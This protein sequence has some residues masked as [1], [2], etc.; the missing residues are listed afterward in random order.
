M[1]AGLASCP[2]PQT[3][4]I[5]SCAHSFHLIMARE[6]CVRHPEHHQ[7]SVIT[8]LTLSDLNITKL[9]ARQCRCQCHVIIS[10]CHTGDGV[11][12]PP[13]CQ[14]SSLLSSVGTQLSVGT[15]YPA[16]AWPGI[17]NINPLFDY[18]Q[19]QLGPGEAVSLKPYITERE[20]RVSP[21]DPR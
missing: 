8:A 15:L 20:G 14:S 5:S 1:R 10:D 17:S 11:S 19:S 16:L 3:R 6:G 12:P 21:T 4:E 18:L 13:S 7:L 9:M 2:G